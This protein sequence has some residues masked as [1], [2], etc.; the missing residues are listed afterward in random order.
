M[1][2]FLLAAVLATQSPDLRD[3]ESVTRFLD[4]LRAADPAV[5]ALG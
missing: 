1:T 4:S 2:V 3:A 5:C